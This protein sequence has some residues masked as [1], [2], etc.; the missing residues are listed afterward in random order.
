M[1]NL[2]Y[3][4]LMLI[5]ACLAPKGPQILLVRQALKTASDLAETRPDLAP[6]IDDIE[7]DLRASSQ[8][9][10]CAVTEEKAHEAV[11]EIFAATRRLSELTKAP[12]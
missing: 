8:S 2:D 10:T 12:R 6:Q 5:G 7:Q 9:L 4:T 1:P 3:N 11:A